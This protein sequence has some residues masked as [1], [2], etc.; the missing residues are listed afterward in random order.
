MNL[1]NFKEVES[2]VEREFN[3]R[4]KA[5]EELR[6]RARVVAFGKKGVAQCEHTGIEIQCIELEGLVYS[7]FGDPLP[8][9]WIW[10]PAMSRK[11]AA[12]L[13]GM[14]IGSILLIALIR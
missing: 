14:L 7:K 2:K 12:V 11:A 8:D 3:E 1:V 9:N 13:I 4:H 6:G 5:S 10:R